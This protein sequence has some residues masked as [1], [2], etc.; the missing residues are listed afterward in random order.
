MSDEK[1]ERRIP[2]FG[3]GMGEMETIDWLIERLKLRWYSHAQK[4]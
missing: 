4:E 2:E 1:G 3:D